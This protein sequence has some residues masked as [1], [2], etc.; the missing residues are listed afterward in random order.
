[1]DTAYII[2]CHLERLR[3]ARESPVSQP[4]RDTLDRLIDI[5]LQKLARL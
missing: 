1:M 3:A 2:A 4:Y 5:D